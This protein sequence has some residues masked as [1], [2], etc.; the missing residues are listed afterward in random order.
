MARVTT[1]VRRAGGMVARVPG[2]RTIVVLLA[3]LVVGLGVGQTY[4]SLHSSPATASSGGT[5]GQDGGGGAMAGNGKSKTVYANGSPDGSGGPGSGS[6]GS[7]NGNKPA[8]AGGSAASAAK[9]S[10]TP[11]YAVPTPHDGIG[12]KPAVN[13]SNCAT[14]YEPNASCTV[15]YDGVYTLTSQPSATLLVQV[16][17]DGSVV[18]TQSY[19]A[20]A[21][22]H[23]FRT[24][25]KFTVPAHAKKISYTAALKN[26]A[27]GTIVEAQPTEGY[28]YG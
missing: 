12:G 10:P 9:T 16:V 21:G 11:T 28:G 13:T 18:A 19:P 26:A 6:G 24:Q 23:Q 17:I 27:G 25:L 15:V 2:G 8:G 14:G 7:G 22:G 20:P 1:P 3:A 4:R 5:T